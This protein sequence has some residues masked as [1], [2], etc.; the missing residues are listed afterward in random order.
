MNIEYYFLKY[1]EKKYIEKACNNSSNGFGIAVIMIQ[2]LNY[3]FILDK[4]GKNFDKI[5]ISTTIKLGPME[6][7]P[8]LV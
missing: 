4:L 7:E 8:F 5:L 2:S 1:Q 6:I 3:D